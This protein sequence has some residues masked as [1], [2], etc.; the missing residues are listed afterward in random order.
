MSTEVPEQL[1]KGM[2]LAAA[3]AATDCIGRCS[4]HPTLAAL[5]RLLHAILEHMCVSL[6]S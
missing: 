1:C 2:G 6:Q 4:P 5:L 3:A